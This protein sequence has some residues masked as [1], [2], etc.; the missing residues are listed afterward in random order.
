MLPLETAKRKI[1]PLSF[2]SR[3]GFEMLLKVKV[4][5]IALGASHRGPGIASVHP[6][7]N[8]ANVA[9]LDLDADGATVAV[10]DRS[11]GLR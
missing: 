7:V 3:R 4:A 6:T 2:D 9:T 10:T 1:T 11:Q 5:I 8:A